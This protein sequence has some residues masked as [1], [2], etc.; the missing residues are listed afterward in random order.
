MAVAIVLSHTL[1]EVITPFIQ[2]KSVSFR[3]ADDS[4]SV[5]MW[6][7][8]GTM[9]WKNYVGEKNRGVGFF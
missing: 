3:K 1:P 6:E 9:W 5:E 4:R 7:K 8:K 2:N